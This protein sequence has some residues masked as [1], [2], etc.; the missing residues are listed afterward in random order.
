MNTKSILLS[1][2]YP[3]FNEHIAG[4]AQFY[5]RQAIPLLVERGWSFVILCPESNL[6]RLFEYKH[7]EVRPILKDLTDNKN[8]L[9]Y[10]HNYSIFKKHEQAVDIIWTVDRAYP[11]EKRKPILLTSNA[12]CYPNEIAAIVACNL[13][14]VVTVSEYALDAVK[15]LRAP[16]FKQKDPASLSIIP[17]F[18]DDRFRRQE[19]IGAIKKYIDYCPDRKYILFPHRPDQG[20][21]HSLALRI[22][23]KVAERD[24]SFFLLVPRPPMSLHKDIFM[25]SEYIV[26]IEQEAFRLGIE[27]NVHFHPWIEAQDLPAYYSIGHCTLN[28]TSL[29]E[30]FGISLIQ[31]IACGTPVFST[32]MGALPSVVPEGM[33]HHIFDACDDV[34]QIAQRIISSSK[35]RIDDGRAYVVDKYSSLKAVDAYQRLLCSLAGVPE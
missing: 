5:I 6:H 3:I 4:G 28:T 7:V 13:D 20:K 24:Q 17:P 33:G 29:P 26:A 15:K 21:N 25:E 9:D 23:K 34:E 8:P 30:T 31:S 22:L 1:L 32:G 16:I 27:E 18:L 2:C 11:L 14:A 12:F 19:D 35:A 10:Q